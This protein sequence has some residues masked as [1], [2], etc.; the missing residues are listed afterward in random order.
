MERAASPFLRCC[1]L[2]P[3]WPAA[4]PARFV[5][6]HHRHRP[7]SGGYQVVVADLNHDGKP[8]LIALASGMPELVWFE[9][10]D[11]GAARHRRPAQRD[12][13]NCAAVD[14]DGDGIPEIVLAS[15]FAN[16]AKNSVGVVSRAA[17]QWRPAAAVD[18]HRDRPAHHVAPAARGEYRRRQAGGG[19]RAADRRQGRARPT[20]ATRRRWS[21]TVPGEWKRRDHQRREQR[22]GARHLDHRLGRRRARRHPHREF[23]GH[24]PVPARKDGTWTRTE[25]AKGDPGGLAEIGIERY[26]G[27][28][29]GQGAI[30]RRHRAVA[31]E[32]GRDLP[33][34]RG[35]VAADGHR[36]HAGGRPH[37]RHGGPESAT[38]AT[39]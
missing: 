14:T 36:R 6:T 15:E 33:P 3:C 12:M 19:Q 35:Q 4:P 21:S 32:P 28:H 25:I 2:F 10:P 23:H 7:A 17:A 39:R 31:R 8:D 16:Q 34:A 26:R 5:D 18:G 29:A 30:S 22:R 27:R 9:N 11:V 1:S 13:I 24:P 20:I 37:H 38:A